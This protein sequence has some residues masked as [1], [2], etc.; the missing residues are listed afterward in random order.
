[1]EEF[2]NGLYEIENI[3][4]YISIAIAVLFVL[5]FIIL[6]L[7]KKDQKLE[8][9]K[10]L[11]KIEQTKKLEKLDMDAF[12]ENSEAMKAEIK[13]EEPKKEEEKKEEVK[14]AQEVVAPKN[15]DF[16]INVEEED[17]ETAEISL[18]ALTA[19]NPKLPKLKVNKELEI[20]PIRKDEVTKE[21]EVN[22]DT[23]APVKEFTFE[24]LV[25]KAINEEP[26][27]EEPVIE[28]V[29]IVKPEV[30]APV[31]DAVSPVTV[32][33]PMA[34][35][36]EPVVNTSE[37]VE[38]AKSI[39]EEKEEEIIFARE[40]KPEIAKMALGNTVFSSVYA[41][42]KEDEIID[43]TNLS[44]KEDIDVNEENTNIVSELV[45]TEDDLSKTLVNT[46]FNALLGE[47]YDIKK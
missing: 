43:L 19:T 33:E 39:L 25:K 24:D 31:L 23:D 32:F 7:G 29:K 17:E 27:F 4:T 44:N 38:E 46:S 26:L 30:K 18:A 1:M 37:V 34:K 40:E 5:F 8:E 22:T 41:P 45:E 35:I 21:E 12:K 20:E 15:E 6:F 10:K 2:I 3:T 14:P 13:K 9:T 16:L 42:K 28:P 36:E 11:Q 47:S